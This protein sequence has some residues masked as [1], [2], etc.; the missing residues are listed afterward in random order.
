[1]KTPRKVT[2]K[3]TR[4]SPPVVD[5][6]ITITEG[7]GNVFADLGHPDPELALLKAKL[8]FRIEQ[9][10]KQSRLSQRAAAERVGVS[11]SDLSRI[12]RGILRGFS[13]D[14]LVIMLGKL[15]TNT[16]LDFTERVKP[17]A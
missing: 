1:M 9:A 8:A 14:R 12:C 5:E 13:M 4:V 3:A 17:V 7:S 2:K 11:Q 10:I 15:G 6:P 16:R